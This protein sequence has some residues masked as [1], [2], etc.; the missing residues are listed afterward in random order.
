[1]RVRPLAGGARPTLARAPQMEAAVVE[2][3]EAGL[4]R[5]D[6]TG[7]LYVLAGAGGLPSGRSTSARPTGGACAT[8]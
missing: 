7:L 3:V 5:A 1:V 4:A 2:L 8:R 6:W